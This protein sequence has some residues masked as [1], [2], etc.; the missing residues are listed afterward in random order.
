MRHVTIIKGSILEASEDVIVN[1]A[2]TH[3]RHGGGLAYAIAKAAAGP[4]AD[5]SNP[6][7]PNELYE[8]WHR[9]QED[10]PLI[11][12]GGVGVTS[13]GRL[14]FRAILHAVGPVWGGGAYYEE[15]LL[16]GC[17]RRAVRKAAEL[18]ARSIAL[19]ALSAGIF[20]VPIDFV[21]MASRAA[22]RSALTAFPL[23]QIASG[24]AMPV[25]FYLT[26]DEHVEAFLQ[27]HPG[28]SHA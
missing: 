15:A 7:R 18:G 26:D 23:S 20:G 27:A 13:A 12:T 8:A 10:H 28:A 5:P 21:A 25:A 9:E 2:N 4:A 3:L 11:P 16:A 19:P 24:G 17:Y 22:S 14:P 1:A 6:F